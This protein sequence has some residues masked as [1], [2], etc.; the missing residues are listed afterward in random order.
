MD[1]TPFAQ[2]GDLHP[3]MVRHVQRQQGH[4][5]SEEL[6]SQLNPALSL[7]SPSPPPTSFSSLSHSLNPT[8]PRPTPRSDPIV[9]DGDWAPQRGWGGP[10]EAG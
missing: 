3:D 9:V 4:V 1:D 5:R 10:T 7:R 8:N 6:R 2:N